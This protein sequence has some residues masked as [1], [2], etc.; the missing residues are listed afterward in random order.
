MAFQQRANY[1][2]PSRE[3]VSNVP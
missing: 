1:N 3:C 2:M